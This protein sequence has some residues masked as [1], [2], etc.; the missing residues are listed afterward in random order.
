M[1]RYMSS[2]SRGR[3][4]ELTPKQMKFAEL[5]VT[6]EGR[7]TATQ[8]AEAAGYTT[9]PRQ[10]ASELRNPNLYPLVVKYIGELRQELQRKYEVTFENHIAELAK[11]RD[12]ARAKGAWSAAGNMEIARGKAAGLYVEQKIIKH[13]RLEDMTEKELE[14]K[15]KQIIDDHKG[16]LIEGD[17]EEIKND[18]KESNG[19]DRQSGEDIQQSEQHEGPE[20][21]SEDEVV[22]TTEKIH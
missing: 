10:T 13:G 3:P 15:M 17:F 2:M 4:K 21:S 14:L 12:E 5:F 19:R 20:D 18:A 7:M 8:A 11:L 16:L 9:R 22:S 6:H 1:L